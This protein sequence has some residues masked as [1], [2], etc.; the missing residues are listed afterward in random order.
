MSIPVVVLLSLLAVA[1]LVSILVR[2][3]PSSTELL[4]LDPRTRAAARLAA[5]EEDMQQLL[6]IT[7]RRRRLA[8][9]DE[10]TE[11]ELR[12]AAGW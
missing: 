3:G 12:D 9:L 4:D 7:N 2:F 8:G 5:E 10:I 6:E 1:V 11:Q